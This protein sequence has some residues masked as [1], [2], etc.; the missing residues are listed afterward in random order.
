MQSLMIKFSLRQ[1]FLNTP[2]KW[3]WVLVFICLANNSLA[4]TFKEN[5]FYYL[6]DESKQLT[7]DDI[8]ALPESAFTQQHNHLLPKQLCPVWYRFKVS[9]P[10]EIKLDRYLDL[11][12]FLIN[13]ATLY[14]FENNQWVATTTGIDS[15]NTPRHIK[16]PTFAF[17]LTIDAHETKTFYLKIQTD[18]NP[19]FSPTVGSTQEIYDS[20]YYSAAAANGISGVLVG[21]LI[22]LLLIS[23]TLK[24]RSLSLHFIIFL[25]S[26]LS[27][28]FAQHHNLHYYINRFPGIFPLLYTSFQCINAMLFIAFF[29]KFFRVKESFPKIDILL[30]L[31]G[32]LYFLI[33]IN[34][35]FF[36]QHFSQIA[37]SF[38]TH[39]LLFL[40]IG[41]TYLFKRKHQP[42]ANHF[43][44]AF[45]TFA[46]LKFLDYQNEINALPDLFFTQFNFGLSNCIIVFIFAII[47]ANLVSKAKE[48]QLKTA[49]YALKAEAQNQAKSD[50]LAK[51]SHEIRT[52]MN[53]VIGMIQLLKET[54]LNDAQQAYI[55]VIEQSGETLMTVIN[56]I[57]D[58]SK[59][60]AGKLKLELTAFNIEN[61]L[62]H[63]CSLFIEQSLQQKTE[64]ITYI[65][66]NIPHTL[67]GDPTR[68]T[69]ILNNLISNA[70][71]FTKNG[72]ITINVQKL[73]TLSDGKHTLRFAITDTGIGIDSKQV[74]NLFKAFEQ[75]DSSTTRLYGGTGLGLTICEQLVHLMQGKIGVTSQLGKGST[76]WFD[77]PLEEIPEDGLADPEEN[78]HHLHDT[79]ILICETRTNYAQSLADQT[80]EW[81]MDTT[82]LKEH[83]SVIETLRTAAINNKPFGIVFFDETAFADACKLAE[84]ISSEDILSHTHC[85]IAS[86]NQNQPATS[87]HVHIIHK[88]INI[89][90]WRKIFIAGIENKLSRN[91][92]NKDKIIPDFSAISIL[93]AEDNE[94]NRKVIGGM[95]KRLG[96]KFTFTENGLEALN[97]LKSNHADFDLVLMDCEMPIMDGYSASAEIR[98]LETDGNLSPIP[99]I[100]LTAHALDELR[101]KSLQHGMDAHLPK[102]LQF[103]TL[104]AILRTWIHKDKLLPKESSQLGEA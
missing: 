33:I 95:L 98:Q 71:K 73:Y 39:W 84:K 20:Y 29:R 92:V 66:K 4:N 14:N 103:P 24:N 42:Y 67:S 54:S 47:L 49:A 86:N 89:A 9:N 81:K 30:A 52:P 51:M 28:Q 93:I 50:F 27:V 41:C 61:L 44:V 100:A 37:V 38:A 48:D 34:A 5:N 45:F 62:D 16:H 99:I 3:L 101:E 60:E 7:I 68:I 11:S 53:G 6:V 69:Q 46:L 31:T 70:L 75:A 82:I 74:S 79:R 18:Y 104:E 10:G 78:Q 63:V 23:L 2:F 8:S 36:N 64:L 72:E 58:Y 55:D 32:S 77:L 94:V 43:L 87:A 17:P 19:H 90:Q 97:L 85:F 102:P 26:S 40:L 13:Q 76:F 59:F 65:G 91:A 80:R 57:L 15:K 96:A 22:Y 88:P 35:T 56:D 12:T 25:I 83:T 1:A 21:G